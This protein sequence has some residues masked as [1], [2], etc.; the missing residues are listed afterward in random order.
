M[1]RNKSTILYSSESSSILL[2]L[3]YTHNCQKLGYPVAKLKIRDTKLE[4]VDCDTAFEH[5]P[6][7]L[8]TANITEVHCYSVLS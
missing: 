2:T 1:S 6:F 8:S 7:K 3:F 4:A 5:L